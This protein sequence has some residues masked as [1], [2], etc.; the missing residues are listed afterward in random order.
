MKRAFPLIALIVLGLGLFASPA[1]AQV[2][3]NG[4]LTQSQS[5]GNWMDTSLNAI[6][7]GTATI[8][9]TQC[10]YR[11]SSLGIN[12]GAN[13]PS[14][15]SQNSFFFPFATN[16]PV[17]IV[18]GSNTETV[19]PSSVGAPTVAAP[20]SVEAYACSITASFS[21]AHGIGVQIISGDAG[22][23]EAANDNAKA[24]GVTAGAIEYGGGCTGTATAS[25]TLTVYGL[26]IVAGASGA[27]A[28]TA[29]TVTTTI[30]VPRP[31][32]L[33]N[34]SITA[35]AGGV[36]SS[37][38]VFTLYKN[39]SASAITCTT[40]TATSCADTTHMVTVGIGDTFYV[41]FT[42]QSGET[43]AGVTAQVEL[44]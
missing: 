39:G 9:L 3:N 11:S 24:Y 29:T 36:S 7:S 32:V 25:S 23:A 42:T 8:N 10:Y 37:S 18:D 1:P 17:T 26:G 16:V 6:S 34:L 5:Y 19:T 2:L 20:S 21:N 13:P 22:L 40:G 33:K 14:G 30:S 43:L 44:F 15:V 12:Q 38:G 28:C 35:T 41:T 31:G 4:N 27:H